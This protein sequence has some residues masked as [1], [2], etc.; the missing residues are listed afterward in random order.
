VITLNRPRRA[1]A[2]SMELLD[3]FDAAWSRAACDDEVRVIVLDERRGRMN[4][5]PGTTGR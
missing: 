4:A 3:D 2:Q 1:N 5:A